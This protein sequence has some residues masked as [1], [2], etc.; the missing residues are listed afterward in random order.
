MKPRAW[1]LSV[2][3]ILAVSLAGCTFEGG[4][5]IPT[6][7]GKA[8]FGFNIDCIDGWSTG[9]LVYH[10]HPI[11]LKVHG[12]FSGPNVCTESQNDFTVD[13]DWHLQGKGPEHFPEQGSGRLRVV[14]YGEG[15][16]ATSDDYVGIWL[17]A[18]GIQLYQNAGF[19]GGGNIQNLDTS[20]D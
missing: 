3:V 8:T 17:W 12:Y 20:Q 19:L 11:R 16:K 13:F 18:D 7:G 5:W 6:A 4:G 15:R 10:D 1:H 14:D 9:E 2:I